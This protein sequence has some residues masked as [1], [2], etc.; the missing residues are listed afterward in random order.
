MFLLNITTGNDA[1]SDEN[2]GA[3]EEIARILK[4]A[5][6][7]VANGYTEGRCSDINGN[8]VGTWSL[9]SEG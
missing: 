4:D 6:S 5:A 2:G 9:K 1:F 3:G 8:T 7:K